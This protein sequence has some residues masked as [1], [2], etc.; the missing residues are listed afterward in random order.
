MI[1]YILLSYIIFP[2]SKSFLM[3]IDEE[4]THFSYLH[5]LKYVISNLYKGLRVITFILSPIM[6]PI[7]ICLIINDL[8]KI[9]KKKR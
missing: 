2:I 6:L 7:N 9:I 3:Y 1:N 8:I 5:L 4:N